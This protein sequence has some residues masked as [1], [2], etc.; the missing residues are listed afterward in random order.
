MLFLV[1][2][3]LVLC[4]A[5]LAHPR[6]GWHAPRLFVALRAIEK[7]FLTHHVTF[8]MRTSC[9][10]DQIGVCVPPPVQRHCH[11]MASPVAARG[12]RDGR[13]RCTPPTPQQRAARCG[14]RGGRT[15]ARVRTRLGWVAAAGLAA[16]RGNTEHHRG[17]HRFAC[18]VFMRKRAFLVNIAVCPILADVVEVKTGSWSTDH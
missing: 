18:G 12:A 15:R 10:Y 1:W 17:G 4:C 3:F 9:P 5:F 8:H 6:L 7:W 13:H 16:A 2:S 14:R 11:C